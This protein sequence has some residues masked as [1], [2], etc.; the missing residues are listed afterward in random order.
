MAQYSGHYLLDL[1]SEEDQQK[2]K[3]NYQY[4]YEE[5]ISGAYGDFSGLSTLEEHLN[6]AWKGLDNFLLCS[7]HWSMTPEGYEYWA[8]ISKTKIK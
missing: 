7:F 8:E 3:I 2:F 5:F 4:E 1:L 6:R